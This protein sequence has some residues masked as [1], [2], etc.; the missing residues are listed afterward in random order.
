MIRGIIVY[1][2]MA[3]FVLVMSPIAMLWAVITKNAHIYFVLGRFC[4]RAAGLL[5]GVRVRVKGAEKIDP[6]ETYVFLSNHQSNADIPVLTHVLARDYRALMKKEMM[7]LPILSIILKHAKFVTVDRSDPNQAH[8]SIDRGAALLRQ[9]YSFIAFPEGTRSR[10]G[11]LGDF[12]K[13]VFVMALKSQRPVLPIT[14]VHSNRIQPVGA[15]KLKPGFVDV[16]IHDPI[17]TSGMTTEDRD[18]LMSQTR[19]AIASALPGE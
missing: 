5:A 3:L 4:V 15:F 8:S 18:H 16:I 11:R 1:T 6:G 13:G 17:A 9:G 12:K 10:N 19:A 14:V 2:F 7:R